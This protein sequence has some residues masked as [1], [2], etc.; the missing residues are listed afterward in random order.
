[1]DLPERRTQTLQSASARLTSTSDTE[2]VFPLPPL[3]FQRSSPKCKA[4]FT[5]RTFH[6]FVDRFI[7]S[8]HAGVER[9]AEKKERSGP[10]RYGL[11][12]FFPFL[13]AGSRRRRTRSS[14]VAAACG[15]SPQP[16]VSHQAL[17]ILTNRTER[18]GTPWGS[19]FLWSR[20]LCL[21]C[22]YL[23]LM[24]MNRLFCPENTE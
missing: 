16:G 9:E 1:M 11:P 3:Q 5:S 15:A 23:D 10:G 13:P 12:A 7:K 14:C 19:G 4:I 17:P 21:S 8:P 22:C 18:F 2:V 6:L 20:Q 24:K